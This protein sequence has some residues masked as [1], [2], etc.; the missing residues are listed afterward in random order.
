M[1]IVLEDLRIAE[2]EV[3]KI[4]QIDVDTAVKLLGLPQ[5]DF[6]KL[7][8]LSAKYVELIDPFLVRSPSIARL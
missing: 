8:E 7:T 1:E 5:C 6:E 4:M 3:C 2:D